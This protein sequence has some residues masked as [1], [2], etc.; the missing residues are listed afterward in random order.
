MLKHPPAQQL[1]ADREPKTQRGRD[2]RD[3]ILRAALR[4][5]EE[6]SVEEIAFTELAA[7]AGVARASLLHAFPHWR[8]VL[9]D[10]FLRE[11]DRLFD[12]SEVAYSM[13]RARPAQK[14]YAMLA[15]VLDRA[16]QTG[17]LYPNLRSATFT[18]HG[19]PRDEKYASGTHESIDTA[20]VLGTFIRIALSDYYLVVEDLLGVPKDTAF[21]QGKFGNSTPVG[22]LLLNFTLDLAARSPS[23]R[24]TFDERRQTLRYNIELIAQGL[25]RSQSGPR[26]PR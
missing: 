24:A 25:I 19:E 2:T 16:E 13:K 26:K 14:V 1:L 20:P 18:W 8:D 21:K 4:L 10:L 9:C 12:S 5:L 23:Y 3:E 7:A 11:V 17:S 15:P 22:E 6:R